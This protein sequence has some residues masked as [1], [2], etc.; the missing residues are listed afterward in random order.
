[1]HNR[2]TFL[3]I[4]PTGITTGTEKK[5][6]ARPGNQ[7]GIHIFKEIHL[8]T[9]SPLFSGMNLVAVMAKKRRK[10]FGQIDYLLPSAVSSRRRL[11]TKLYVANEVVAV[12]VGA[13][14]TSREISSGDRKWYLDASQSIGSKT[15][16]GLNGRPSG[17]S[18]RDTTAERYDNAI[19]FRFSF[20]FFPLPFT[21]RNVVIF[22]NF[23][24]FLV[25]ET[26]PL[27]AERDAVAGARSDAGSQVMELE[28]HL[29]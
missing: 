28:Q 18:A 17:H 27:A 13:W 16:P 11:R 26:N 12:I 14:W 7:K 29:G 9:A 1:M 8:A 21:G 25:K 4:P 15:G 2:S 6:E 10:H 22:S 5:A 20:A 3:C 19:S 24:L 23:L